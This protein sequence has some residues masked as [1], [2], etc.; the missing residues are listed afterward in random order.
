M[1]TAPLLLA[2]AI[3]TIFLLTACGSAAPVESAQPQYAPLCQAA[4]TSCETPAVTML[5]NQYCIDRV[6]YAIMSVPAGTTYESQ[7]PDMECVDQLH[8]DGDLRITCHS[9]SGKDLWSYDLKLC[10]GACSAL[11]LE[12]GTAQCQEGYGYDSANQCCAAP[13]P[14]SS[15]GCTVYKV[16][17]GVCQGG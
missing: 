16:N 14:S 17:L 1:R 15:D 4:P 10:N 12:M 13:V 3:A 5:D 7:D 8:N 2:T 9:I 6:P 11:A